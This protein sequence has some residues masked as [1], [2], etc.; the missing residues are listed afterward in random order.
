MVLTIFVDIIVTL[1]FNFFFFKFRGIFET[2]K[3]FLTQSTKMHNSAKK[4]YA[5]WFFSIMSGVR[6]NQPTRLQ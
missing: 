4:N 1:L 5:I 3:I 2:L 6:K